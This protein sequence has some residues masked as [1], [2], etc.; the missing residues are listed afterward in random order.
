MLCLQVFHRVHF[1]HRCRSLQ[2]AAGIVERT[3]L[4][5]ADSNGEH[6]SGGSSLQRQRK[7]MVEVDNVLTV[8][9]HAARLADEFSI[10][11]DLVAGTQARDANCQWLVRFRQ[12]YFE[13]IPCEA[14]I[15]P[16]TLLTPID[17]RP[18]ERPV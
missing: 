17:I 9:W 8:G 1:A 10:G 15:V 12:D 13:S 16:I 3:D 4:P 7:D 6:A 2:A 14:G 18:Q 5:H 11:E